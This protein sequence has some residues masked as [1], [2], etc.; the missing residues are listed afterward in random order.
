MKTTPTPLD[1]V[2]L[3][4]SFDATTLLEDVRGLD[5]GPFV[6]YSVVPL[7]SPAHLVDPSLPPPP[8]ADDYADGSWTT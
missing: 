4:I 8:P 5:L 7:R 2:R 3:P 1:R 6:Y